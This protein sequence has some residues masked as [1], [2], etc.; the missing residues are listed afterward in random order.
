M[1]EIVL[2]HAG[3]TLTA[4]HATVVE[5]L[6]DRLA[7]PAPALLTA[8][9]V[10]TSRP[11]AIG[12]FW[13]GEGGIYAGLMRGEDG[14]PD[15]HL[16]V[17]T[18]PA[19]YFTDIAWGGYEHDEPEAT[20]ERDGLANTRAL[21][22]SDVEHPAAEWAAGLFIDG[23]ADF[24]LPSRRELRLCWVNVPELFVDGYY[25]SSTQYSP[26]Y[27]WLQ[28]FGDGYQYYDHK[29]RQYRARAVRRVLAL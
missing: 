26:N 7:A 10:S 25:W 15:W 12:K 11:P 1:E 17:P 19:A 22:E 14:N 27:A 4:P 20:H 5:A 6:L 13:H 8:E 3:I 2:Q 23:R 28:V 29:D 9:L 24:Y 21:V 18:D 16:I